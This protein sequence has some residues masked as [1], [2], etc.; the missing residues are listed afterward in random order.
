MTLPRWRGTAK[1]KE[2]EEDEGRARKG[3]GFGGCATAFL[4]VISFV[5]SVGGL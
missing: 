2:K 4:Y 3:T 1:K 5:I